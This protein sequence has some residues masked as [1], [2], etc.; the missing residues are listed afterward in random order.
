MS[1]KNIKRKKINKLY[2]FLILSFFIVSILV[3]PII[4]FAASD[5]ESI[6]FTPQIE[7]PNTG[8]SGETDVS[9]KPGDDGIIKSTLLST[10]VKSIYTY[11]LSVAGILAAIMIMG[12]GIL[13]LTSGGDSGKVGKAKELITGSIIGL[14][15]L[16]GANLLLKT[17]N[18]NLI[19]MNPIE[20][21]LLEKQGNIA[22][23]H[24]EEGV[25]YFDV[26]YEDDVPYYSS[27][28][29][30]IVFPG[31]EALFPESQQCTENSVC[32]KENLVSY[33]TMNTGLKK[34]TGSENKI[35]LCSEYEK[36]NIIGVSETESTI[37]C[38]HHDKGSIEYDVLYKDNKIFYNSGTNKG[39]EF[40]GC[41]TD[42]IECPTNKCKTGPQYPG[43]THAYFMCTILEQDYC[44]SCFKTNKNKPLH[45]TTT[46]GWQACYDYCDEKGEEDRGKKYNSN[47]LPAYIYSCNTDNK[48]IYN[49]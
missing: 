33:N 41:E 26:K 35:Y 6:K 38:C 32:K 47:A 34:Y 14:F 30:K 20:V 44:C 39:Q 2:S 19:E 4:V 42:S 15:I 10:Y 16:F 22:C 7:F 40:L 27:G 18:P 24:F 9:A 45:C 11:G 13:W 31:C 49:Y 48:C 37:S 21:D 36:G 23:C 8:I 43:N 28:S 5:F 3:I 1:L 17:I 25:K 46:N 12:A 29:T